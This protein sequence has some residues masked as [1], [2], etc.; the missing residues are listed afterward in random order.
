[1]KKSILGI[2]ISTTFVSSY[3]NDFKIIITSDDVEYIQETPIS[4]NVTYTEWKKQ[5]ESNCVFS[6]LESKIY[7]GKTFTQDKTCDIV[8][9]RTKTT[10]I[11]YKSGKVVSENELESRSTE[12]TLQ[13]SKTGTHLESSCKDILSFDSSFSGQD[14]LYQASDE[15][16]YCD[17]TREGGGWTFIAAIA[18]DDN[19]H[20]GFSTNIWWDGTTIGTP[21]NRDSDYQSKAW[22][23][24]KGD[25]LLMSDSNDSK[26]IIYD[27][28]LNNETM[29]QK[30]P[31]TISN[32]DT[33]KALKVSGSWWVSSCSNTT[34]IH[35]KTASLDSD[36]HKDHNYAAHSRGFTWMSLNNSGCSWDDTLGGINTYSNSIQNS[37][38]ERWSKN[39]FYLNNFENQALNIFVK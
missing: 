14:G 8:E 37:K 30:I 27:T 5:S 17:M 33:Y 12:E 7:S 24:L 25:N 4:N 10:T 11:N 2:I 34:D 39:N 22:N 32:S 13:L 18:D 9:I 20:W 38:E 1:M 31:T 23:T 6:P 16:L 36:S 29:S 19:N 26:F 15:P 35:M 28:V 3:S 21:S